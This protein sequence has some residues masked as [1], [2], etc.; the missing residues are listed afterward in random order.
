MRQVSVGFL[1]LGIALMVG[2][3]GGGDSS[4]KSTVSSTPAGPT[5]SNVPGTTGQTG[6]STRGTTGKKGSNSSGSGGAGAPTQTTPKTS[7]PSKKRAR[8]PKLSQRGLYNQARQDCRLF[9]VNSLA[10]EYHAK[11]SR[12]K[13]VAAAYARRFL[14]VLAAPPKGARKAV[15]N[16]CLAALRESK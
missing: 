4:D 8:K 5:T 16:G 11:S 12:P 14:H 9:P 7:A 3:C 13:D 15:Y 10:R 1:I 6:S 2:A